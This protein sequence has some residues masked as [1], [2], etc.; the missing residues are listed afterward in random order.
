MLEQLIA[1]HGVPATLRL[2][3][4]PE[5]LAA[6]L[7]A[8]AEGHGV[9]LAFIQPGK[10]AQNAFIE[11]FNQTYRTEVLDAHVFH[12]LHEARVITTDWLRCYN[13]ERPH[14]SL[15]RVPPLTFLPRPT[16]IGEYQLQLST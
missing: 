6:H 7:H 1:L 9:T 13:T 10:P 11:R 5:F 8:W 15:G 12:S 16:S 2:D 3:N 14:D 4:G